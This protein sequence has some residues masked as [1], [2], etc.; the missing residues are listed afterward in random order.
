MELS[1]LALFKAVAEA[2]SVTRAGER[3]QRVQSN[4]TARVKRLESL[5]GTNGSSFDSSPSPPASRSSN[6]RLPPAEP[7]R[8][9]STESPGDLGAFM[10]EPGAIL[11]PFHARCQTILR[12]ASAAARQ[13]GKPPG[14][15]PFA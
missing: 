5:R 9:V 1:D 10:V 7:R 2:G 3:L 6:R 13:N 4:V 12:E 15:L 8:G 11:P 14:C